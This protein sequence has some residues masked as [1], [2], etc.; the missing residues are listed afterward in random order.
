M[1]IELPRLCIIGNFATDWSKASPQTCSELAARFS[2]EGLQVT[3]ASTREN[4][5]L[6]LADIAETLLRCR[7]L[8]DVAVIDMFSTRGMVWSE[9]AALLSRALGKRVVLV[10]R[11]GNLLARYDRAPR[12]LQWQFSR[13]DVL[14]S[15]SPFLAEGF[16]RRS[17]QVEVI[18]NHVSLDQLPSRLRSPV[19]PELIWIRAFEHDA[20]NPLM[21][22]RTL[23]ALRETLP[24]ARL[25]MA[26]PD[27]GALEDT[28]A[29]ARQLGVGDYLRFAGFLSKSD[30][31]RLGDK[32]DILLNTNHLDNMPV[33][34]IESQAM[35]LCCVCTEIGGIPY[36]VQHEVDGLLVPDDDHRAM[37]E[38]IV[39]LV[40]TPE[41]ARRIS[42]NAMKR[43]EPYDWPNVF[44]RWKGLLQRL[45]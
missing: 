21:A 9:L 39:K 8:Y 3:H 17:V 13:A 27:R 30:V 23:A 4:P 25:T 11:G 1:S 6:R 36:I 35:G 43:A 15:P 12:R 44:R 16:A 41:L 19:R 14:V 45:R 26:G 7:E 18:F 34:V 32:A 2:H 33:S 10:L 28:K 24:A 31:I 38:Q 22:V 20:Y 40:R 37:A 5:L 29:L 42:Q